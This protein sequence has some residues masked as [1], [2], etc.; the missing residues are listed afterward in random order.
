MNQL[1]LSKEEKEKLE[2]MINDND[3]ATNNLDKE[4]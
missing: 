4:N 1:N 3:Q 2:R